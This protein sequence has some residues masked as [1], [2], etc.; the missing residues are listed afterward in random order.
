M[1]KKI[2]KTA[3]RFFD[4]QLDFR[5]RLFNVL[6]IA[7]VGISAATFLF[8]MIAGIYISA[9]I[10]V[11]LAVLSAALLIFTYKTGKYKIGYFIT[12]VTIFMIFFPILFFESGGYK[13]GMP[14][15]FIFAVL[16]TVLMLDGKKALFVS[17]AEIA[18]YIAVSVIG[19]LNPELVTW[20][21]S[22]IKMLA[23]ILTCAAAVSVSCGIVLYLHFRE[24][25]AQRVK[26]AVRNEQLKRHDEAKS[27][28]LTTVA[29]EIKNPLNAINLHARDTLEM[30]DEEKIDAGVIKE[31]QRTIER[32][33][34]RIDRIVVELMDTVAIEQG[35]LSLDLAPV[36]LT[37]IM[38]EAARG[39]FDK[40]NDGGNRLVLELDDNLPPISADYARIMQV[41][42]NLISNSVQHTKNGVIIV[43]VQ[44]KNE[45]HNL[46]QVVSVSDNGDGMKEEIKNKAFEGYVS[47]NR[48]YW[49]HGIGLYVC[50]RIIE[51]HGGKIW[52]DSELGKGTTVYFTLP[53]NP[54]TPH[55]L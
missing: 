12:I 47:V 29:H 37:H 46:C 27:V 28:F 7:G 22:D 49:R 53:Q 52:I 2:K 15:M 34:T 3:M 24:Y 48:E 19:Y 14:S 38:S 9:F 8:N 51:A 16:F 44:M 55:N 23:D 50:H 45:K 30:L 6:A 13:S 40:N 21:D 41:A 54:D 33:V 20:F 36:R 32:M 42:A 26:L 1:L 31:N 10:S 25:E 11:L 39:Y 5:V 17:L 18:E 4:A 43:R 35:R